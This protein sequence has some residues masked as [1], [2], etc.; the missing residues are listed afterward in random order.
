MTLRAYIYLLASWSV[1]LVLPVAALGQ[2]SKSPVMAGLSATFLD[3][4]GLRTGDFFRVRSFDPGIMVGAH[5]YLSPLMNLS[6]SSAF[7]P[8]SR[9]PMTENSEVLTSLIDINAL[10]K[11]KTNGTLLP[12]DALLAPYFATGF[13]FNTASNNFRIY[14]PAGLGLQIQVNQHFNFQLEALYKQRFMKGHFQPLTY[15]AGFVFAISNN[16]RTTIKDPAPSPREDR[17]ADRDRDGVAD[18]DDLCPDEKGLSMYLG[19]PENEEAKKP[20]KQPVYADGSGQKTSLEGPKTPE[21]PEG[22][23]GPE[24]PEGPSEINTVK[25]VIP[26]SPPTAEE[27]DIVRKASDKIFFEPGSDQLTQESL[28]VLDEVAAILAKHPDYNLEVLG[29]TDNTGSADDN[30]VLSIKRAFKVKYYL[31][32]QKGIKLSRITSD[33]MSSAKPISDNASGQGRKLNRRVDLT[34]KPSG[35]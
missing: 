27:L 34:L 22:P 33:G 23:E 8:E 16:E 9:Y 25:T 21:G 7:V 6:L 30:L 15:S 4:N 20:V 29:H 17:L 28:L 1:A 12:E 2:T 5:V 3:Y 14:A 13:G 32:Y 18:R 24:T 26:P 31:V 10:V 35:Y 19:C 11:F